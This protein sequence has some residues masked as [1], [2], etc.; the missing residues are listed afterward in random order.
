MLGMRHVQ[1][2][3]V[4]VS[5]RSELP[6]DLLLALHR[7]VNT[8]IASGKYN[9]SSLGEA[10]GCSQGAIN[11]IAKRPEAGREIAEKLLKPLG[12]RSFQELVKKHKTKVFANDIAIILRD[13]P[14]LEETL[15][16]TTDTQWEIDHLVSLILSLRK[17]PQLSRPDGE[18]VRGTW[19]EMLDEIA[20]G[21]EPMVLRAVLDLRGES[22]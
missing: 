17:H 8:Q 15:R 13:Y 2:Y 11:K 7:E 14:K 9:Q 22:R 6:E 20:E 4:N 19:A 3:V 10:A 16:R 1:R 18:P 21:R 12:F 5:K